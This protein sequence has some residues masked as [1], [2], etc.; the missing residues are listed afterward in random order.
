MGSSANTVRHQSASD[1]MCIWDYIVD[2]ADARIS[3]GE[4]FSVA[5]LLLWVLQVT[6]TWTS[7]EQLQ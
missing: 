7:D 3:V 5:T 4:L 6:Y 1:E 2:D